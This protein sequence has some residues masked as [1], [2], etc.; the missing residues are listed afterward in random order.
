[1]YSFSIFSDVVL[2]VIVEFLYVLFVFVFVVII[3]CSEFVPSLVTIVVN[4]GFL[5]LRIFTSSL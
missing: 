5:W 1:V 4:I 3:L 2:I